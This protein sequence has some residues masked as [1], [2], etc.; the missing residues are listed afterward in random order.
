[1]SIKWYHKE[2]QRHKFC[3]AG[4]Y[5]LA[6]VY[7]PIVNSSNPQA[8]QN[9]IEGWYCPDGTNSL[10]GIPWPPGYYWSRNAALPVPTD[11]GYFAEKREMCSKNNDLQE[12]ILTKQQSQV[13]LCDLQDNHW[14]FEATTTPQ[15]CPA[16]SYKNEDANLNFCQL[17]P[18]GTWSNMT[19][20]TNVSQCID[21]IPG[22]ACIIEGM[23]SISK[24]I[25][26]P[27]E[28]IWSFDK[29]T[30]FKNVELSYPAGYYCGTKTAKVSEY[31]LWDRELYCPSAS[32]S[33]GRSQN[34]CLMG[35]FWPLGTAATV[36][37]Q[38]TFDTVNEVQSG[39]EL[40]G[41]STYPSWPENQ[42]L[43]QE[44]I[45]QYLNMEHS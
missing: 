26:C 3:K 19:G 28:Y 45:D 37:A 41:T 30:N 12:L 8:A 40:E 43:P 13:A 34:K 33:T 17:C 23:T 20:L 35:Y 29:I 32:T 44:L 22:I 42:A 18:Q 39:L 15:L 1:M 27:E 6:G 36:N 21:C 5:C 7:T 10:E 14:T 4:I 9:C 31:H 11:P 16:G 38:E 2:Y 25:D 24:A